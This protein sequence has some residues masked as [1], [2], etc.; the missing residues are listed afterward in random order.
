[1][2]D[3]R[4]KLLIKNSLRRIAMIYKLIPKVCE[5][6]ESPFGAIRETQ[7]FCSKECRLIHIAQKAKER[8]RG[9]YQKKEQLCWRCKNATGKCMWSAFGRP[10][11]GWKVEPY[12]V[13]SNKEKDIH[14]YSII[15]CPQFVE[16]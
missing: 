4:F 14:T 2:V 6:C 15:S 3:E 10:V 12:I 9:R 16:G 5:I 11:C 13:K 1:M 8:H 7:K